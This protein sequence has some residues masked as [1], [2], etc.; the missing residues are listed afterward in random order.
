MTCKNCMESEFPCPWKMLQTLATPRLQPLCADGFPR[1]LL[2]KGGQ[3]GQPAPSRVGVLCCLWALKVAW[4]HT[5]GLGGQHHFHNNTKSDLPGP[6][7]CWPSPRKKAGSSEE[8][9]QCHRQLSLIKQQKY[10]LYWTANLE[11]VTGWKCVWS[12]SAAYQSTMLIWRKTSASM[13]VASS[14]DC[15]FMEHKSYLKNSFRQ[16][17]IKN[18]VSGSY[19]LKNEQ[20]EPITSRK[21]NS[22]CGQK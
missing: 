18:W 13:W 10:K 15:I 1:S 11:S 21:I 8:T 14:T 3:N 4:S 12:T 20:T 22:S 7:C 2:H 16:T 17:I 6:R 5:V 9:S 19:F